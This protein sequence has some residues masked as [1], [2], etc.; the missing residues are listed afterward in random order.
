MIFKPIKPKKMSVQIADQI[1]SSIMTGAFNP[2]EKLPPER[3]LAEL[4]K[5]SRPT[6]REALNML[7]T[8]GL[9]E[10]HQGGGSVVRSLM[11]T[12]NGSPLSEL[13]KCERERA[14]TCRGA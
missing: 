11:E 1:R 9:V 13:I 8:A 10:T 12:S 5:V 14:L 3:E 7:A 2:G 4:F 6:V